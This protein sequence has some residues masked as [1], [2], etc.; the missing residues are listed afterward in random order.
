MVN[1]KKIPLYR[2]LNLHFAAVV[3]NE[4]ANRDDDAD[5]SDDRPLRG[6]GHKAALNDTNTL[7]EPDSAHKR[8]QYGDDVDSEFH[9]NSSL[10]MR[11]HLNN[12]VR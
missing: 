10:Y 9:D 1:D 7:K 12:P 11:S 8:D 5:E 3:I 6:I 2:T 4:Q